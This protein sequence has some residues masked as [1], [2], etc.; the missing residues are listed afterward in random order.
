MFFLPDRD[1]MLH[2]ID[3]EPAGAER[4]VAMRGAHAYPDSNVTDREGTDSMHAGGASD[5]KAAHGFRH[6][7]RAFLFCELRERLVF[8]A[9]DRVSFV[10]IANPALESRET[11]AGIVAQLAL[12]RRTVQ[13]GFAERERVETGVHPPAT[14]GM[15]TT[16]SPAASGCDQSPNSSL[17]ATRSISGGRVNGYFARSSMYNSRGVRARVCS[18]SL[19]RPGL[20]AQQGV[21]LHA[22]IARLG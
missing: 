13:W 16:A 12:Q 1:A 7:A 20:F 15:N 3:D 21:V 17:T 8:Q 4:L 10:V 18:V 19:L 5:A 22:N 11:A 9:R 6:D 2:F 14:G